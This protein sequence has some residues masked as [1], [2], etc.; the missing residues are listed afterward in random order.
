MDSNL[1][2]IVDDDD[3]EEGDGMNDDAVVRYLF[4]F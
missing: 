1:N 2:L 3:D 4:K